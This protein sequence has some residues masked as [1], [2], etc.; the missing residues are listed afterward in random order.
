M[1][2]R[3]GIR[4]GYEVRETTSGGV[5]RRASGRS[6]PTTSSY[7]AVK[8]AASHRLIEGRNVLPVHLHQCKTERAKAGL[9]EKLPILEG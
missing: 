7:A 1:M 2:C 3:L 9:G 8:A 4:S 6:S 5:H